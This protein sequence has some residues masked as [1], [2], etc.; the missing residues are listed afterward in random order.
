MIQSIGTIAFGLAAA[1]FIRWGEPIIGTLFV[2]CAVVWIAMALLPADQSRT[3][4]RGGLL[5]PE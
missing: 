4:K 3:P 5:R 2:V 1:G